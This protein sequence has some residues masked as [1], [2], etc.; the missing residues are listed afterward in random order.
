MYR[1]LGYKADF[2]K[3]TSFSMKLSIFAQYPIQNHERRDYSFRKRVGFTT[4]QSE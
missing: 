3:W 4:T 1:L 2:I